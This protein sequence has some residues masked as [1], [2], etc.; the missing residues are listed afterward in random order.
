MIKTKDRGGETVILSINWTHKLITEFEPYPLGHKE[1]DR[2]TDGHAS[3]ASSQMVQVQELYK[4]S[5]KA[6][7]AIL[8]SVYKSYSSMTGDD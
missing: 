1:M 7:K 3:I 6:M 5:G 2:V 4:P 8:E